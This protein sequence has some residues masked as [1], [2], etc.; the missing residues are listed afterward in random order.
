MDIPWDPMGLVEGRLSDCLTVW[1]TSLFMSCDSHFGSSDETRWIQRFDHVGPA[2]TATY[3]FV[4]NGPSPIPMD[5]HHLHDFFP[6]YL[7]TMWGEKTARSRPLS[8]NTAISYL[9]LKC[10][11]IAPT[12]WSTLAQ[13]GTHMLAVS[14]VQLWFTFEFDMVKT[15]GNLVKSG[16]F[17]FKKR[18][19]VSNMAGIKKKIGHQWNLL[20]NGDVLAMF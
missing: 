15:L 16:E 14:V 10:F 18:P 17:P 12:K 9:R 13:H 7:T 20:Q 2:Q 4:W 19:P 5:D 1:R 3:G 11:E 8:K 6:P